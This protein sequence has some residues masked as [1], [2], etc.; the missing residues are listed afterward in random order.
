[1]APGYILN[2]VL[3]FIGNVANDRYYM[4]ADVNNQ[5]YRIGLPG[6]V[7]IESGNT[8][9]VVYDQR[10]K[11]RFIFNGSNGTYQWIIN[12]V[13]QS[14]QTN[15][16]AWNALYILT[17]SDIYLNRHFGNFNVIA[18]PTN[19]MCGFRFWDSAYSGD[20]F[21]TENLGIGMTDSTFFICREVEVRIC[22]V[23]SMT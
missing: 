8:T 18:P 9:D 6:S 15:S 4:G 22:P 3:L 19:T 2:L 12:D 1:M 11:V 7:N 16:Y 10:N 17:V 21:E 20:S 23:P 13:A 5:K 14:V